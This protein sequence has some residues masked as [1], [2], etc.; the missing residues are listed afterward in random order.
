MTWRPQDAH[1]G[2]VD[3][4][5]ETGTRDVV[6]LSGSGSRHLMDAVERALGVPDGLPDGLSLGVCTTDR[7][8][9]GEVS[10]RL[11]ESVRGRDV[12]L[13]G[14]TSPPVNDRLVELIAMA[15]ACRRANAERLV[16]ILPYFGYARSDRRDGRRTPIMARVAADMIERSGVQQV[17]VLDV[18]TPA[19]EGFFSVAVDHLTAVSLL[20]PALTRIAPANA[21]VVAPDQGAVRLAARYAAQ[22]AAPV[23][24]CHKQRLHGADVRVNRVIGEVRDR[25]CIIVDDMISTGG[26]IAECARA[27]QEAG[28]QPHPL[29]AATHAVFAPGALDRLAAAGVVTLFVTDSIAISSD[30]HAALVP[31]VVSIAPM[32]AAAI[33]HL[34]GDATLARLHRRE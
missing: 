14:A 9:D 30:T 16:V 6:L 13:I 28:A 3:G 21:V 4:A 18:H 10:V 15:D 19:L 8:P 24:V 32:L 12:I 11:E 29:V 5:V 31:H 20:A 1:G 34:H 17:V 2:S 23:A 22:L 33:R 7:F 26:T 27:L 25:P